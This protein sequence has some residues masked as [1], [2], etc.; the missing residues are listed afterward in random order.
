M[1]RLTILLLVIT[2]SLPVII[3]RDSVSVDDLFK[4]FSSERQAESVNVNS[5]L[6][7]IAKRCAGKQKGSEALDKISSVKV[8][9]LESCNAS[10]KERFASRANH[11]SVKDMEPL[12]EA[13][14]DG[15]K[16][17]VLAKIK[18]ET[19]Q[20]LLVMCYGTEDCCLVEINGK[21][22]LD[23]LDGVVKSQ[24]PQHHER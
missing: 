19:I 20:R 3:A 13:N 11:V 1:K 18:N 6:M 8:L 4:E 15:T 14:D 23:E 7:W 22:K 17:K 16:V 5:F 9:D 10:V 24:I 12:V 21:F 2:F